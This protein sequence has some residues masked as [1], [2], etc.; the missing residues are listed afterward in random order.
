MPLKIVFLRPQNCLFDSKPI[1]KARLPPSRINR[2]SC[3]HGCYLFVFS[4]SGAG[5][6]KKQSEAGGWGAVSVEMGA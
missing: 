2:K 4:C 6:R 5:E 1:A 3:S